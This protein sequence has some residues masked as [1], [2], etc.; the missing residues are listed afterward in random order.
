MI[1]NELEQNLNNA[2]QLAHTQKHEFVTV[3][4]LLLV[5]LE[6]S[7]SRD[8]LNSNKVNIDQL[9]TDLE[10]FIGSTTPKIEK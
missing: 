8:L 10:E 4:H 9:R 7:D 6:N 3:E 2:F 1:D 5:L